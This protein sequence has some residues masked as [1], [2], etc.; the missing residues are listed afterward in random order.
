[1]KILYL[2]LLVF[3]ISCSSFKYNEHK[4]EKSISYAIDYD[5][6]IGYVNV[7]L[8]DRTTRVNHEVS[9]WNLRKIANKSMK[10]NLRK[11][12]PQAKLNLISFKGMLNLLNTKNMWKADEKIY[13][14]HYQ[15]I[16]KMCA[17][18]RK[19][20][21]KLLFVYQPWIT[22]QEKAPIF[23]TGVG[24]D[25]ANKF[26]FHDTAIQVYD[27]K[28]GKSLGVFNNHHYYSK[29]ESYH[30]KKITITPWKEK[31]KDNKKEDIEMFKKEIQKMV[32]LGVEDAFKEMSG[33]VYSK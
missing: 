26:V 23:G 3:C 21:S 4:E 14:M 10:R 28:T 18:A 15:K 17:L 5:G 2:V 1:M 7:N 8:I 29:K 27:T 22:G 19:K 13:K 6:R 20:G 25:R 32:D 24:K 33:Y 12:F 31:F 16:Q 30:I 9:S 11:Y